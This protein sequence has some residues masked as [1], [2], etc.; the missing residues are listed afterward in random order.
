M[1]HFSRLL[2][3]VALFAAPFVADAQKTTKQPEGFSL[4]FE[5]F[6]LSNGLEVI[7]HEDHSD[8]IVA[9]ATVMHVGSN[10]E[11]PGK[12]G[13]AHFFEHMS[14]ND[15]ENTPQGA[16][17]KLI[18]E[19]GGDRNGGTWSDG[20][21]YYEVVPKDAFDK[22]LWIDSDRLGFMINTV[23]KEALEAE[24]QVVKNEKRE[25]VD[26]APYGYTDEIIRTNLY[27]KGHPYSWTVIGSL[28]DL[29]AATLDDVK[30]FYDL[31][32]GANNATL[33]IAGDID[34]KETKKKVERWFGE[35]RKGPEVK[36]LS[37]MPAKL[38]QIK[39]L[40]FEDNFAKLPEL[41][42]IY[43]TIE[44]YHNDV[45]ALEALA[46]L[47]S[48]SRKSP[49]F[50]IIVEEKKQAPS[51]STYQSSNEVAGEFVLRV[52]ANAG[53]S[54]DDVKTSIE[55]GFAQFEKEGFTDNE[56]QRVKAEQ[57][58]AIYQGIS[59]V[60]NKAFTLA[61]DNEFK[62]DPAWIIKAAVL[63][64]AV[65]RDDVMRVYNRYIKGKNYLMTSVVPKG[66]TDLIVKGATQATVWQEEIVAG[67]VNENVAR[68][69][70][71]EVAKTKTKYDRSEPGFGEAPL[72][73][74]PEIWDS[75]LQ[76]GITVLG[77]DNDEVPLVTF[78]INIPGGHSFDPL[79]KAGTANLMAHLLMQGT[80]KRTPAELEEALGLLGSSIV[81]QCTGEEIRLIANCMA[82]NFSQTFALAKEMLVEPRWDAA[83][84]ER[85][86]KALETSLKGTEANAQAI[87]SRA[88]Y[89]LLYGPK[90]IL[91][92][93]V[94]GTLQSTANITLDDLK[95]FYA[96]YVSPANA[97]I[98]IA[99]AVD[100]TT[101]LKTIMTLETW[102]SPS[103][104]P[105]S[106]GTIESASA[107]NVYFIDFPGAKQSV[108][109]AGSLAL[110]ANDENSAKL[111]FANE[112]LGG[113]S[114]GKLFQTL[115]IDKGY[116]YGAYSYI[117]KSKEKAPFVVTTSVR[118]NATL[119]SLQII[120]SMVKDYGSAFS[121]QEVATTKNKILKSNT[122]AYESLGAKLALL[123]EISKYGKS[124][125][126]VEE[127]QQ[128][129]MKMSLADFKNVIGKYMTEGDQFYL[130]VGDKETQLSEVTKLKDKV[131][132]LDTA[133][134]LI[135]AESD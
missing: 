102:K 13:F 83:E 63:T 5:K 22:I 33:V 135:A 42:M 84:Y 59:T 64:N 133:G 128:Q 44:N 50:K 95:S 9:V 130:V 113:G 68:G 40:Y 96:A 126:F 99:G 51:V 25:R 38:D 58:T 74:M 14:F 131:T 88:F 17:R 101:A 94:N 85:L 98:H 92:L 117:A 52:R 87:A 127:D 73:K 122:L 1:K 70:E 129:L 27:P 123:R 134:M 118:S 124:R 62:G 132:L 125:K 89:K 11:K 53:T 69:A 115:R 120:E 65:T 2:A 29:Q 104:T 16:N 82:K 41:R 66:Q 86:K 75:K 48:G 37:P 3:L 60:L 93:P 55:K 106:T 109:Y 45:Y 7:L 31:Y 24:K 57:E 114:S 105:P 19:W 112:I 61:Q 10:R 43:P 39:S 78:E 30:E 8:P 110:T 12:T 47:L 28:P 103:V 77:V 35:I 121:E 107:G 54:L 49:L 81:I 26:N 76:N 18:P 56:L 111:E 67:V 4:P 80:A 91:G 72:F 90:H 71:A 32:Y 15:S 6:T 100:K 34:M 36:G 46:A 23:T 119:P 79:E 97:S 20:T 108:I 21:I 116:T